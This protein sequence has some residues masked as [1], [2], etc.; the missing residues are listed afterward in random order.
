MEEAK[1][2]GR[3]AVN[4]DA[5]IVT[6]AFS[7]TAPVDGKTYYAAVPLADQSYAL[8]ALDKVVPADVSKIDAE[9]R[10][11]ARSQLSQD[12]GGSAARD[13]VAALRKAEK[14]TINEARLQE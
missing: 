3:E 2:T 12:L 14:I 9:A 4:I 5:G 11:T 1:D 8:V 13:L 7:L 10:K 6:S